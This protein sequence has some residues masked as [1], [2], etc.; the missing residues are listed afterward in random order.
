MKSDTNL[1]SSPNGHGLVLIEISRWTGVVEMRPRY[2]IPSNQQAHTKWAFPWPLS[3]DLVLV[4]NLPHK[5]SNRQWWFINIPER[6]RG[7]TTEPC[8]IIKD[9]GST[10]LWFR[11]SLRMYLQSTLPSAVNPEIAIPIW[12]S[13]LNTLRWKEDN[14]DSDRF[15]VAR[16][17]WVPLCQQCQ[18]CVI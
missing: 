3:A 18:T 1:C 17:T 12:S 5:S 15:S 13:T 2:I 4:G 8:L 9:T 11:H 14:S 7:G 6:K 16:T 10:H